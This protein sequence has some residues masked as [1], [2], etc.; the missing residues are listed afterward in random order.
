MML[1]LSCLLLAVTPAASAGTCATH[2]LRELANGSHDGER[3]TVTGIADEF[4]TDD[5]DPDYKIL[6]LTD[7]SDSILVSIRTPGKDAWN[8]ADILDARVSVSGIYRKRL[9]TERRFVLPRIV[10]ESPSDLA[11]ITP[12]SASPFDRPL[13][14]A[15]PRP[16]EAVAELGRRTVVGKVIAAWQ[17]RHILLQTPKPPDNFI[18]VE[19]ADVAELPACGSTVLAV[20]TVETDLFRYNLSHARFQ[21]LKDREPSDSTSRLKEESFTA[22]RLFDRRNGRTAF[23]A[24]RYGTVLADTGFVRHTVHTG[25]PDV[26]AVECGGRL[27]SLDVSA[28]PDLQ[29]LPAGTKVKFSGI[30]V[31]DVPNW[32]PSLPLPQIEGVTI[33]LRDPADL[34][35]LARPPWWT[36]GR[37]LAVIGGL[38]AA[39]G[40]ILVW[41]RSLRRL[42]ERRG[43][44]LTE[45]TVARVTS[46]FK[47]V[48]RTRLAVELHD[49]LAQNLTGVSL[50]IDTAN[51]VA[52]ADPAT[53]HEQLNLASRSLKSCRE[54]LRY[55]LWDLRNRALEAD[56]LADAIRQ[57]LAPHV[58]KTTLH[59]R[60]G[61]PRDRVTD[62]TAHAMLRIIRELSVNAVRHG[63]ATEIWIAGSIEGALLRFSVRDNGCGFDPES[64]PGAAEGHFG[65][66]GIRERIAEFEGDYRLD[67]APGRGTK[68]TLALHVP[69]EKST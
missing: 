61:V 38:L 68:V 26:L 69:Q 63:K 30:C 44:E 3:V 13:L 2:T 24:R 10:L 8:S 23:N 58:G 54:E 15:K 21:V 20:G 43:R 67:S 64:A 57:T 5:V 48:E 56:N 7:G 29:A 51:K 40:A 16:P 39:L 46:E 25:A 19:L 22:D 62:S 6:R 17:R 31:L 34:T 47:V 50:E 41:N 59:I 65:L 32:R 49:S 37:L 55:C 12:P 27:L 42:A 36:A 35:V 52:D 1:V 4:L 14:D 60:F 33:V 11:V 66:L 28:A 53:M 9:M 18:R 45:E